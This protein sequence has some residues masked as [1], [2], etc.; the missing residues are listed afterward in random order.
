M[1]QYAAM[2]QLLRGNVTITASNQYVFG[3]MRDSVTRGKRDA[4]QPT[5][6]RVTSDAKQLL[7]NM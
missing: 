7:R 6:A 5:D 2:S 4:K 3:V 1:R